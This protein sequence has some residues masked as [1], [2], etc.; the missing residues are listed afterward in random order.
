MTESAS[1]ESLPEVFDRVVASM[2]TV[3][4]CTEDG[5]AKTDAPTGVVGEGSSNGVSVVVVDGRVASIDLDE[6]WVDGRADALVGSLMD[7]LN[8]ALLAYEREN[9]AQLEK[10]NSNFGE[11]M[12]QL[13]GLQA[14]LHEAYRHDIARLRP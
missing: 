13:G 7:A 9:V 1:G 5:P 14:D 10:V 11:V 6:S 2:K 8:A 12:R 4:R 3:Q